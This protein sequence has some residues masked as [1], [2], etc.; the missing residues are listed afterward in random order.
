MRHFRSSP[1]AIAALALGVAP[2][3]SARALVAPSGR[4]TRLS[5]GR[6]RAPLATVDVAPVAVAADHHLAVTTGT[7]EQTRTAL[8]RLLLPMRA[9]LEPITGRYFPVGRAAHGCGARYRGDCAGQSRCRACLSGSDDLADSV[10]SFTYFDSS[11]AQKALLAFLRLIHRNSPPSLAI[12]RSI[13]Q[14]SAAL[15]RRPQRR[16]GRG[17][18]APRRRGRCPRLGARR[19]HRHPRSPPPGPRW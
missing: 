18:G 4:S 11:P 14:L 8:H 1:L 16:P 6:L 10:Q 15:R 7:V 3:T 5:P 19:G 12:Y 13:H 9:G 17:R 2:T